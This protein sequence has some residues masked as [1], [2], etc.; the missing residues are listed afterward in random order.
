MR[1]GDHY[2]KAECDAMLAREIIAYAA[3]LDRCLIT[4]VPIGMKVALDS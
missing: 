3:A 2:S 4:D 1:P